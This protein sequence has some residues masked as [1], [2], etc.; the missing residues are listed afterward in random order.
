MGEEA[1][2]LA[3]ACPRYHRRP[4]LRFLLLSFTL[5]VLTMGTFAVSL[6]ALD[7]LPRG[8]GVDF[9]HG[10]GQLA[11][12]TVVATWALE[13]VALT[14]LFLL[15]QGRA[16][17]WWLDGLATGWLAWVFRG[18]LLV[19]A[20]VGAAGLAPRPW[21]QMTLRWWILYSLCGL[22]VAG[23]ARRVRLGR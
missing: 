22:L 20:V 19:M 23:L 16:G 10:R 8:S 11:A 3:G 14:A 9:G 12:P 6:D 15:V 7:L 4:V 1:G 17:T 2:R 18:P 5:L 21:W 13:A